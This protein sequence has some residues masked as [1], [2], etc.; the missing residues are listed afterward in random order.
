[1]VEIN[2]KVKYATM[3]VADMDESIKFYTEIMG[4]EI[5]NQ[6]NPY[7]GATITFLKGEKEAMI[8]LIENVEEPQKPGLLSVGMEVKDMNKTV[9]ELKA[10]GAKITR[11]P[12]Q[13]A[14]ETII[15]FIQDPNGVQI[16]LI[17]H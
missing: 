10:K 6:I 17:Q 12:I 13:V 15:A 9:K 1:M 11:G 5:D 8:E 16:G 7:P 2:M 3:A 14:N 4:L